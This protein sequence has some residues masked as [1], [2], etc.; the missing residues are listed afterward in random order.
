MQLFIRDVVQQI[1]VSE[2]TLFPLVIS[3]QLS[4]GQEKNLT[5]LIFN[6]GII[7]HSLM[8]CNMLR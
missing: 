8:I 6:E 7:I 1:L 4:Q 5:E 2:T 3:E